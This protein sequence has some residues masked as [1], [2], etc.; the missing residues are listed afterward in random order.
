MENDLPTEDRKDAA[1]SDEAGR[2]A[3]RL[4]WRFVHK[5]RSGEL[6]EGDLLPPE[7]DIVDAYGVSRTV[8]REAVQALANKGLVE[9]RPRFRPVVRRP[10]FDTVF[11]TV[12]S[13]V[14]QLLSEPA[15]I[16]N[17]FDTRVMVEASLARQAA[18]EVTVDQLE[19][20]AAALEANRNAISNSRQ[21]F[22]TDKVFHTQLYRISD[23]P[24]LFSINKAY[25]AWLE[26]QWSKM[27]RQPE[28]NERNYLAHKAIFE[29]IRN[30]DPDVAEAAIRQHLADAWEQVSVTFGFDGI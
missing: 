29:A 28:R 8:V 27:P 1:R 10:S 14:G 13:V 17:L 26:P 25:V 2:A 12:D 4:F 9:A 16:R 22:E 7:R 23:N 20:M 15:G 3:D 18:K 19:A 5:I 6:S 30:G 11:Q 24:V 21:F